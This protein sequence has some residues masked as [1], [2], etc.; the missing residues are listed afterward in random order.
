MEDSGLPQPFSEGEGTNL[1]NT[2]SIHLL[3]EN[4]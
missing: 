1:I 4:G 3:H 2:K